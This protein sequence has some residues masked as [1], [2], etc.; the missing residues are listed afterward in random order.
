MRQDDIWRKGNQIRR[1]LTNFRSVVC[2][3]TRIDVYVTTSA[4]TARR[5]DL[6]KHPDPRLIA[7]I[8]RSS[9]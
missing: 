3:E 4:P 1:V 6:E 8:I 5:K 7:W 9:G 2:R